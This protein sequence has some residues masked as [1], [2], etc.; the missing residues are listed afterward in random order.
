MNGPKDEHSEGVG[1]RKGQQAVHL[2]PPRNEDVLGQLFVEVVG[3]E[4]ADDREPDNREV[5]EVVDN[6]Q[7]FVSGVETE[8]LGNL[9]EEKEEE[10]LEVAFEQKRRQQDE[11]AERPEVD[12]NGV[13]EKPP[14]PP[15]Q[16]NEGQQDEQQVEGD[17]L[18]AGRQ[19]SLSPALHPVEGRTGVVDLGVDVL[20]DFVL[21]RAQLFVQIVGGLILEYLPLGVLEGLQVLEKV[22]HDSAVVPLVELVK[23]EFVDVDEKAQERKN[24]PASRNLVHERQAIVVHEGV[25][26]FL[27]GRLFNLSCNQ[28]AGV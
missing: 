15:L 20:V 11:R 2:C 3:Q 28:V 27:Q 26:D 1:Q 21:A 24:F 22:V 4:A 19:E 16:Q 18:P 25:H 6:V 14:E 23:P 8:P 10:V 9:G 7:Q 5:D 12:G 13:V 17:E